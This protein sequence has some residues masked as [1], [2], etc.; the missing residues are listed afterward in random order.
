PPALLPR[1]EGRGE[2]QTCASVRLLGVFLRC[3]RGIDRLQLPRGIP[4]ACSRMSMSELFSAPWDGG[5]CVMHDRTNTGQLN[6]A[7][8]NRVT[9]L[10]DQLE[11]AWQKSPEVDLLQF[12]PPPGDP[13]RS[14]ILMELIKTELEIL[15]RRGKGVTLDHYVQNFPEL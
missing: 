14:F 4:T 13:L 3:V 15:W 8:W 1:V 5:S 10:A 9:E 6:S 11:Q 7:D 12:L 2:E